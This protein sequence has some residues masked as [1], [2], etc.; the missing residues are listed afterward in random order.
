V[1]PD[2][3]EMF[4]GRQW[5]Q[6]VKVFRHFRELTDV[7]SFGANKPPA[8]PEDV[9]GASSQ[10]VRKS[11]HFGASELLNLLVLHTI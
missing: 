8:H 2:F 10:K 7:I 11:S 3:N 1:V 6:D 5:H 4:S 9:E